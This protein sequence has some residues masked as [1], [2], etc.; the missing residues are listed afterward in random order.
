VYVKNDELIDNDEKSLV[1]LPWNVGI[2]QLNKTN[3][4]YD[5]ICLGS[6]IAINVVISGKILV[7]CI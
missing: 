6:I 5:L 1:T 7:Q 2:Y 4:N 3:S